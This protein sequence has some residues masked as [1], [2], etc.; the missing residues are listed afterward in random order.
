MVS[1]YSTDHFVDTPAVQYYSHGTSVILSNT[2]FRQTI[3]DNLPWLQ[4][5]K[6]AIGLLTKQQSSHNNEVHY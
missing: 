3:H 2:V 5:N 1:Y 6:Q 4:S